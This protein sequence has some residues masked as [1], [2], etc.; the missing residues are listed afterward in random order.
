MGNMGIEE[1][2]ESDVLLDSCQQVARETSESAYSR[3]SERFWK[4]EISS[5]RNILD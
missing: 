4:M 2:K 1:V 3:D 5:D